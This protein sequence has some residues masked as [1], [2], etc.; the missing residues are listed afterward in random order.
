MALTL[1]SALGVT[2][3]WPAAHAAACGGGVVARESASP[4]ADAQRIFLSFH[5]DTTDV[6]TVVKVPAG[7]DEVGLL[8]PVP[9]VPTLDPAPVPIAEL[10]ALVRATDPEIL[11]SQR[12]DDSGGVGCGCPIA[13]SSKDGTAVAQPDRVQIGPATV[14]G[15]VTAVVLDA[16]APGALDAWLRDNGLVIPPEQQGLITGYSAPGRAFVAIRRTP[17]TASPSGQMVTSVGVHMTLPGDQRSLPLRFA[18]LG[19]GPEVGFTV[20]V[21]AATGVAASLPWET[22][23]IDALD[24]TS[25]RS[26]GYSAALRTTVAAH[27]SRA[28]VAERRA[29][30]ATLTTSGA[31]GPK[32]AAL[33]MPGQIL[34]RLSTR[35]PAA[36]LTEDV[37]FTVPQS[38]AVPSFR[39]VDAVSLANLGGGRG[40]GPRRGGPGAPLPAP[41]I[42]SGALLLAAIGL[43][44]VSRRC[45][46]PARTARSA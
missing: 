25:L 7:A 6:V 23:T 33:T 26:S 15:P 2:L 17:G 3:A 13:A 20:F 44:A 37:D 30:I 19:A 39:H 27:A 42:A 43:R 9:M 38:D 41:L 18:R 45:P 22:V 35:L 29:A 14:I 40:A 10:D 32:L 4:A 24:A 1:A 5:N 31:L 34:T 28:F 12:S 11:I 16:G 46:A 8:I 21:A 36:A